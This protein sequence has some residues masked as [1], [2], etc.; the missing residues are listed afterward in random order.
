MLEVVTFRG[1]FGQ[2]CEGSTRITAEPPAPARHSGLYFSEPNALRFATKTTVH[3]VRSDAGGVARETVEA[4][5]DDNT[6]AHGTCRERCT[7]VRGY[8]RHHVCRSELLLSRK[9]EYEFL[10]HRVRTSC[11]SPTLFCPKN[12]EEV[13][14]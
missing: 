10:S 12:S 5:F 7:F 6:A 9:N 14:R 1:A 13:L 2:P 11:F 8:R 3:Q 4:F